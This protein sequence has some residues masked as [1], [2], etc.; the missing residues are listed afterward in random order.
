MTKESVEVFNI[1]KASLWGKKVTAPFLSQTVREELRAHAIE[2]LA[3]AVYPEYSVEK[4]QYIAQFV[5]M[6]S[7]Q[8]KILDVLREADIPSAVLKGVAAG[9][10]YPCPYLRTYGDIDILVHPDHYQDAIHVLNNNGCVQRGNIGKDVTAFDLQSFLIELHQQP[11]GLDR[12]REGHYIR[13]Y[14][15]SGLTNIQHAEIKRPTCCFPMLPWKQNGLEI[16][17]HI[18]EHLYNGIGL[19]QI[20]DWMMFVNQW[21][22]TNDEYEEFSEVLKQTGLFVFAKT[23]T[24][25]C[26]LYLGLDDSVIWCA[27]VN[28]RICEKLITFILEQG[29]FGFKKSDD[30][31]SKVLTRYRDP[32]SFMKGMQHKGLLEWKAAKEHRILR[33]FAWIHTGIQGISRYAVKGGRQLLVSDW[34]ENLRRRELFDQLYGERTSIQLGE[35][36]EFLESIN[37]D[38]ELDGNVN[39]KRDKNAQKNIQFRRKKKLKTLYLSIRYSVLRRPLFHLQ[40]IYFYLRYSMFGKPKISAEDIEKVEHNV[41]FIYKSFNR[42]KQ[43]IRLYSCIKAYYPRARVIIADDSELPLVIQNIDKSDL[44]IHLPFNSGLSKGLDAALEKVNTSFVMRMDDDELLTPQTRIHEQLS[45]LEKH[46][47]VDLVGVQASYWKP[48]K[49]AERMRQFNMGKKLIIPAGKVIDGREVVYKAPN[50]YLVRTES[51]RRIGY[52]PKIR[53]MDHHEF[54]YRAAGQIVCVQDP[55]SFIMHC[56]NKFETK[57]YNDYRSDIINDYDYINLKHGKNYRRG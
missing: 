33:P 41:T 19:R 29:N 15:L 49:M 17:W 6:V 20:I 4:Y 31:A 9:L 28:S 51:L 40:N 5:Q 2:G 44:I 57:E 1:I 8:T 16:I 10:Y 3:L 22:K 12:V 43:A 32:I 36:A 21:L 55:H 25:M 42:R 50:V 52:D 13:Q 53:I 54:F 24:K 26:Q 45:F 47:E 46:P 48:E 34:N 35:K 39:N 11:P 56:H 30:K 18:R 38:T 23:V 7:V 27:D 14:I 37:F